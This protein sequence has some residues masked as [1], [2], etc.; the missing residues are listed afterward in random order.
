MTSSKSLA[1]RCNPSAHANCAEVKDTF[2][3]TDKGQRNVPEHN[4]A[5]QV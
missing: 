4:L 2:L 5:V 3:A 1:L